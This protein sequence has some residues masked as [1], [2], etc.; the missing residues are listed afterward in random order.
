MSC[1]GSVVLWC[2]DFFD[3][4]IDYCKIMIILIGQ[5]ATLDFPVSLV[6]E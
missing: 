3:Y 2:G 4:F 6:T 1:C 5:S